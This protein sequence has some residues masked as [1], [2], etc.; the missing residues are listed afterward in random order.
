MSV[1][2]YVF[3]RQ[4]NLVL[5]RIS[6]TVRPEKSLRWS[7]K[8]WLLAFLWLTLGGFGLLNGDVAFLTT[9][10][11]G[12]DITLAGLFWA[13]DG[14]ANIFGRLI[15]KVLCVGAFALILNSFSTLAEIIYRSFAGLGLQ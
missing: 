3:T 9:T 13:L 12:I 2:A 10:L 14:E 8:N 11:I 15:N 7:P 1:V 4:M 5:R 6:F